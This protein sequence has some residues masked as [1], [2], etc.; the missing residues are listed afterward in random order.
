M[1]CTC[2]WNERE[3]YSHIMH[4][5]KDSRVRVA[6]LSSSWNVCWSLSGCSECFWI[7]S[8]ETGAMPLILDSKEKDKCDVLLA[9]FKGRQGVGMFQIRR[10]QMLKF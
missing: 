5:M 10:G 4:E 8:K 2:F 1:L 9:G 3:D 6:Y 7:R